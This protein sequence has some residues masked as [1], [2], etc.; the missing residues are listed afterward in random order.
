MRAVTFTCEV[1]RDLSSASSPNKEYQNLPS[2]TLWN[3]KIFILPALVYALPFC[4]T[5]N[6]LVSN[7]SIQDPIL[8]VEKLRQKV[9]YQL[10]L[11]K[12]RVILEMHLCCPSFLLLFPCKKQ[13]NASMGQAGAMASTFKSGT[14][15]S[16]AGKSDELQM[17]Y[18]LAFQKIA[19]LPVISKDSQRVAKVFG[20]EWYFVSYVFSCLGS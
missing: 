3:T 10:L 9:S 7:R 5:L 14:S 16:S 11:T 2:Q 12:S 20:F 13:V 4:K 18:F 1:L 17:G 8:E 15:I 6:L 19:C